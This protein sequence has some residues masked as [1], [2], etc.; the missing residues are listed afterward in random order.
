MGATRFVITGCHRSGT[1]YTASVMR[2]LG[3]SCGHE[4]FF[5]PG[6][7]CDLGPPPPRGDASWCAAPHLDRLPPGTLVFHQV[8]H[9]L[10]VIRSSLARTTLFSRRARGATRRFKVFMEGHCPAAAVGDSL[11]RCLSYWVSWNRMIE[12]N[13]VRSGLPYIRYCIESLN[14]D[15]LREML[16]AI[17]ESPR[18]DALDEALQSVPKDAN[19]KRIRHRPSLDIVW[20]D[21]PAGEM[22]QRAESLALLYG[23][24]V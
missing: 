13:A 7:E 22:K 9:P 6:A 18:R 12:S 23:Y 14:A 3:I 8:R 4:F 11:T 16:S 2:E 5:R 19:Q 17:S 10:A 21:I 24:A 1:L 20:E 15:T